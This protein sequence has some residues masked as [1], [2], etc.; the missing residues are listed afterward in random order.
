MSSRTAPERADGSALAQAAYDGLVLW[1]VLQR[2]QDVVRRRTA[3]P[4]SARR[5]ARG[6]FGRHDSFLPQGAGR[7]LTCDFRLDLGGPER[8]SFFRWPPRAPAP[9]VSAERRLAD[10]SAGT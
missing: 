3:Q 4:R 8:R 2:R 6:G 5:L 9:P 7:Q 1:V 10:R